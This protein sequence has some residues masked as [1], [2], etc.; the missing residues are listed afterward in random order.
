MFL[1]IVPDFWV[2]VQGEFE[3]T[4]WPVHVT[5][6]LWPLVRGQ[7]DPCFSALELGLGIGTNRVGILTGAIWEPSKCVQPS[8]RRMV[9]STCGSFTEDCRETFLGMDIVALED[10]SILEFPIF[11]FVFG[12][13]FET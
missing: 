3:F 12:V 13:F 5:P 1:P 4:N 7:R 10:H 2:T 9:T 6:I 8:S 11:G